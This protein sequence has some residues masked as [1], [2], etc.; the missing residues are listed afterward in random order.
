MI[1]VLLSGCS[2]DDPGP[3]DQRAAQAR[4]AALDA[5]LDAD[6]A[7]FLALASRGET[8]TYQATYPGPS[9]TNTELVVANDPP[10][11]RID[12]LHGDVV[13]EVRLVLDGQ[14]YRCPRDGD[15]GA[16]VDCERTDAVVETPGAF[17]DAALT[18]LTT[19]LRDGRED[20]TFRITSTPIAGVSAS[21]LVTEL[22]PGHERPDLG[23]AGTI[24]VSPQGALLRVDQAGETLEATD[25][26]T[27]I[28]D[29]TF[30]RPDASG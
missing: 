9:G 5:G 18:T 12:V 14:A 23:S 13:T 15:K 2:G 26:A 24:C 30:V 1:A 6:V 29:N 10:D 21:C 17:D 25:Y 20:F 27:E 22:R 3:G 16:I 7:D 19:A 4:A 28:P 11:R 8:A